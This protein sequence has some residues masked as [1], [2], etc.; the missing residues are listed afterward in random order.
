MDFYDE[1]LAHWGA[2]F[3]LLA[4]PVPER[5]IRGQLNGVTKVDRLG[6][7]RCLLEGN[8]GVIWRSKGD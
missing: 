4:G 2:E 7:R 6:C 1:F 5:L 3:R 8:F